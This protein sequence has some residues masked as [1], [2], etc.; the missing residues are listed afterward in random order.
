[1]ATTCV[2]VRTL[3][4]EAQVEALGH[5]RERA[6]GWAVRRAMHRPVSREGKEG[7]HDGG[8][9]THHEEHACGGFGFGRPRE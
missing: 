1:M 9:I 5:A 8:W 3:L 2:K 7:A 4:L 6:A